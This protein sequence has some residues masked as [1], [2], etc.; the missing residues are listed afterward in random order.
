MFW[1][2]S[3]TF[4]DKRGYK[5]FSDSGKSVHRYVAEK[6]LGRKLESREVVHHKNRN[7]KDN[8]KSNLWVFGSQEKHDRAHKRDAYRYGKRASYKGYKRR[9]RSF[10]DF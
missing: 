3:K 6:K 4:S 2:S 1:N 8:R 5:R 9:R 10:W 7:K